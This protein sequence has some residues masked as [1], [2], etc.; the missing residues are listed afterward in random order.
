MW[1]SVVFRVKLLQSE[2]LK[3]LHLILL[4]IVALFQELFLMLCDF[5][6]EGLSFSLLRK[7]FVSVTLM[8][9]SDTTNGVN[10]SL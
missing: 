7:L 10:R 9:L 6:G 5:N 2:F 8:I 1:T 4:Y 3:S